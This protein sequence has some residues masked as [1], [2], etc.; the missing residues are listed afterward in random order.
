MQAI[1]ENIKQIAKD[2][3]ITIKD[4]TAKI[5]MTETGFYAAIRNSSLKLEKLIRISEALDMPLPVLVSAPDESSNYQIGS[6]GHVQQA[7]K[8]GKNNQS[9]NV[10]G[11]SKEECEDKLKDLQEKYDLAR[12]SL[13]DKELII[14]M[15]RGG[16]TV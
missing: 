16:R 8:V 12:K 13:A 3:G 6:G 4:L 2:K 1:V 10:G 15:L 14:E 7:N 9:I 5:N 11:M